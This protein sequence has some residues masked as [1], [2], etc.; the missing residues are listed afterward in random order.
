MAAPE[1]SELPKANGKIAPAVWDEANEQWIVLRGEPDGSM[2]TA[3][4]VSINNLPEIQKVQDDLTHQKVESLRQ[5]VEQQ[6]LQ[7]KNVRD[8]DVLAAIQ[9]LQQENTEIKQKQTEILE[10]LDGTFDAQLTGSNVEEVFYNEEVLPGTYIET[11]YY[12]VLDMR[13]LSIL[14]RNSGYT[15]SKVVIG[16]SANGTNLFTQ[17]VILDED[18]LRFRQGDTPIVAPYFKVTYHN[19]S[20]ETQSVQ[21]YYY[22]VI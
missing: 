22:T 3:G 4:N 17:H 8:A 1:F 7:I 20:A 11:S 21:L 19:E 12:N 13:H 15:R 16:W 6:S 18:T 14:L 9:S 5:L 2:R 10:R